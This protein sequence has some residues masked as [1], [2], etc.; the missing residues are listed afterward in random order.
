LYLLYVF[1]TIPISLFLIRPAF[2]SST[3]ICISKANLGDTRTIT[4]EN[5]EAVGIFAKNNGNAYSA[6]NAGTISLENPT[7]EDYT[8]LIGMFA[9]GTASSTPGVT[10]KASV[11]NTG[12]IDINTK[13]SVGMYAK[14]DTINVGDV[15]LHNAGTIN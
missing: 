3:S 7:G 13:K 12:T 5:K 4:L 1:D 11:K 9:Q 14:N 8:S 2:A 6:L 15:D 10:N